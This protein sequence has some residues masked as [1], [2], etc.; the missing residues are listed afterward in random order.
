M[1]NGLA[2]AGLRNRLRDT[3]QLHAM[4]WSFARSLLRSF[5][6]KQT[7]RKSPLVTRC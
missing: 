2:L 7:W 5:E 1:I 3:D 6:R 4:A